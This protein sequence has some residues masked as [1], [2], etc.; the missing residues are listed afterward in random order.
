MVNLGITPILEV[1]SAKNGHAARETLSDSELGPEF[2]K[3]I[4]TGGPFDHD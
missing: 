4:K 3:G 2:L 1:V